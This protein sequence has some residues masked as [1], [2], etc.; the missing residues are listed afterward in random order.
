[1]TT[2]GQLTD[3]AVVVRMM[4]GTLARQGRKVRRLDAGGEGREVR[5]QAPRRC[6]LGPQPGRREELKADERM[7]VEESHGCRW[8]KT[9]PAPT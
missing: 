9:P 1:M 5:R 6:P 2:Y 4:G 3:A 8:Q 7:K